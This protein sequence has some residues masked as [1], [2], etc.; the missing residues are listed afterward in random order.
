MLGKIEG[1][2]RRRRKRMRW[3]DGITNSTDMSLSKLHRMM[4]DGEAWCAAVHWGKESDMTEQLNTKGVITNYHRWSGLNNRMVLPHH[5]GGCKSKIRVLS[6]LISSEASLL[7]LQ[8]AILLCY[9]VVFP[10][11]IRVCVCVYMCSVAQ[12]CL[13]LCHS[14]D[15]SAPGSSVQGIFQERI[16][17][18]VAISSPK[19]LPIPGIKLASPALAGRFVTIEPPGTPHAPMY[20]SYSPLIKIPVVLD[21][22]PPV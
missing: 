9:H 12:F 16:L 7:S 15:C 6:S 5:S 2:R 4:K 11:C 14:M 13:T 10:L 8:V 19:D 21:E 3:L 22:S 1:R 17:E 18:W 20:L